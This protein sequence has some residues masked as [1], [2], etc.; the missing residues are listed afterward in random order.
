[1]E[2][3]RLRRISALASFFSFACIATSGLVM[4]LWPGGG[5]HARGLG[6][7]AG[8]AVQM[9]GLDRHGWTEFHEMAG[10]VFVVAAVIHLTLNWGPMKRH[11]GFGRP[12]RAERDTL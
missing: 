7:A 11:L 5:G 4:L 9:F 1:M 2:S 3:R 8:T 6:R 10:I 12:V